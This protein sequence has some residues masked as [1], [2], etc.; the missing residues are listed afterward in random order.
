[1]KY[2]WQNGYQVGGDKIT[3]RYFFHLNFCT[4]EGLDERNYP[5]DMSPF[6]V[7]CMKEL[8][9]LIDYS[10]PIKQNIFVWKARDKAYSYNMS[11]LAVGEMMMERNNT[12]VSLFPKG[13]EVKYKEN[14]RAKYEATFNKLP[15]CMKMYPYL[16]D[17]MT[18]LHYGYEE[19]DEETGQST[20]K[21]AN[22]R[23]AFLKVTRKD[24]AKSFRAKIM[25]IDE[26]GEIDCLKALHDTNEANMMRGGQKFGI[27]IIGGT[28]NAAHEGY[29]DVCFI[30]ENADKLGFNKFFI[31]R[32]RALWGW[33]PQY[34]DKGK[35]I[36]LK[37]AIDYET[38][39]SLVDVAE[40]YFENRERILKEIGDRNGLLEFKQN[41]PK[42]EEDSFLRVT[43]SP[44][45]IEELN[46]QLQMVR[47][48]K[49]I[50]SAVTTGNIEIV[51]DSNP[52]QTRFVP[53]P[54]GRW[55]MYMPPNHTLAFP[56]VMGVD[57][58][59]DEEAVESNSK[60]AIVVYRPFQSMKELSG[61]PICIYHHRPASLNSFFM[62]AMLTSIHFN[63]MTLVEEINK[64][65]GDYYIDNGCGRLLA[66]RPTILT[67]MGSKAQNR[68]GV[69]PNSAVA[70]S[71]SLSYAVEETKD[72]VQNHVF[73]ELIDELI[74]AYGNIN[75][76]LADAY[77]W[78]ILQAKEMIRVKKINTQRRE[79]K[80]KPKFE[81]CLVMNNGK[82]CVAKSQT[83]F[84]SLRQTS[85]GWN[86]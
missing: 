4:V 86:N 8:F 19:R 13:E 66:W 74:K 36:G 25:I 54:F 52:I 40:N 45:P 1:M 81:R 18:E 65:F 2:Y 9:D 5:T 69:K 53:T 79:E 49:E 23:I 27:E 17:T 56:D 77:R 30:W 16:K 72:N 12:I 34:D 3:G 7:D 42:T 83:E 75:T 62:D 38:G 60:N 70:Q 57:T 68:W 64:M 44:Y 59:K 82:L 31:P 73:P 6:H 43:S 15:Q 10:I 80:K 37:P 20:T 58:V 33:V 35:D 84:N 14:F 63:A 11:S 55:K 39:E 26:A 85:Y 71:V 50:L 78:A 67:E 21:G 41:Y 46:I 24:V 48:N 29:K 51:P 47:T 32:Y 28:S 61:L 76:D 22:N